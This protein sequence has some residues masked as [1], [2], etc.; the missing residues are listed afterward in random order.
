[1]RRRVVQ[2]DR[3]VVAAGQQFAASS[4]IG[5]LV[6]AHQ[7]GTHRHL[8]LLCG[9]ACRLE[10]QSHEAEVALKGL[11]S[12]QGGSRRISGRRQRVGG[13]RGHGMGLVQTKT[14]R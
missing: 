3:L 6:G 8:A 11:V 7:H 5:S 13:Q 10:R 14:R 12:W 4:G 1:M 2:A 9:A